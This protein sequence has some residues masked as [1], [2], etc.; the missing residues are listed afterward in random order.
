MYFFQ[1]ISIYGTAQI[2]ENYE[3]MTLT[4]KIK[5]SKFKT[6]AAVNKSKKNYFPTCVKLEVRSGFRTRI[7]STTLFSTTARSRP[8]S[9]V[10]FELGLW[11]LGPI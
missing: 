3:P 6:G 10:N 4:R 8:G 5:Q 2:I 9:G 11:Q 1:K 7:R